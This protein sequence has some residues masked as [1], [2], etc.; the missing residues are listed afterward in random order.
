MHYKIMILSLTHTPNYGAVLQM[1]AL[2]TFFRNR[3]IAVQSI[4]YQNAH[5]VDNRN[6]FYRL[7]SAIWQNGVRRL[8]E[9]KARSKKTQDF[10]SKNINMTEVKYTSYEQLCENP[11]EADI[12]LVGSDQVWNPNII[13]KDPTW[14]LGFAPEVKKKKVAYAASFGLPQLSDD[15]GE[16]Y[17]PLLKNL[18]AISV[19][20][21]TGARIVDK[22]AA[23]QT[24]VVMDPVFLLKK[25]EWEQFAA[26]PKDKGYVLCYYMPGFSQV[27]RVIQ[28]LSRQ[29]ATQRGLKIINIGKKEYSK[30]KFWKNN[31]FGSGP[32]EFIGLFQNADFIVTNSF[33]GTA[34]SVIFEKN[35]LS[36]ID[37]ETSKSKLSSRIEDMLQR[38]NLQD[39]IVDISAKYQPSWKCDYS[40]SKLKLAKEVENSKQFLQS[41]IGGLK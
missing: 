34:F 10:I 39:Q 8:F 41:Y 27:E 12:Y 13:G 18:D 7:R 20:E 32:A 16:F 2:Q 23:I 22:L 24:P 15:Y 38:L 1:C 31:R 19:R 37:K 26:Q 35:F 36:V 5:Y 9:D 14:F 40:Q 21:E 6:S 30:L 29:I 17:K 33:H 28:K 3:G 25:S 11:P 4:D